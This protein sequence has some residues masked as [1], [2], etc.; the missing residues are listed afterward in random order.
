LSEAGI[1]RRIKF[2]FLVYTLAILA[3]VVFAVTIGALDR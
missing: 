1:S 2:T 3:G